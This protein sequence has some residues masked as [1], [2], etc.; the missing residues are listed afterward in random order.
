MAFLPIFK[1]NFSPLSIAGGARSLAVWYDA[2]DAAFLTLASTAITQMLDRSGNAR[3]T[4]VQATAGK[5]PTFNA[6]GQN[7]KGI[8]TF[9][10]GDILAMPSALYTVPAGA[11]TVFVVSKRA[12][13]DATN[14]TIWE[15]ASTA[16]ST[17]FGLYASTS[18]AISFKNRITAAGTINSTGNTNTNFNIIT[19]SRTGTTQAISVNAGTEATNANAEDVG[20]ITSA[21]LGSNTAETLQLNGAIA[22]FIMY[23]RLLSVAEKKQVQKYLS[24]KWNITIA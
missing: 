15:M 24:S 5:R 17:F 8:A 14:D 10:G 11:N 6:T 1:R 20:T 13:E 19:T 18:G 22:E 7:S 4:A 21:S 3:H 16:T 9:D 23:N 12:S 2:S